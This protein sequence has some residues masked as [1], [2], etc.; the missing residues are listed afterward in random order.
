MTH[1]HRYRPVRGK[2]PPELIF[3]RETLTNAKARELYDLAFTKV[4]GQEVLRQSD[5]GNYCLRGSDWGKAFIKTDHLSK[6]YRFKQEEL[7]SMVHDPRVPGTA[8][9]PRWEGVPILFQERIVNTSNSAEKVNNIAYFEP[10]NFYIAKPAEQ[11]PHW[12]LVDPEAEEDQI[13]LN[14]VRGLLKLLT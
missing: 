13:Y 1:R 5:E 6:Y 10:N 7:A 2:M 8:F 11:Y 9:N 3:G 12:Y 14:S 4:L